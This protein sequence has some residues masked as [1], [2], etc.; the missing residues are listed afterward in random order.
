M[1]GLQGK[2]ARIVLPDNSYLDFTNGIL[3]GGRTV[4][5]VEL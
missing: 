4:T 5:G 2:S 3:T 1:N